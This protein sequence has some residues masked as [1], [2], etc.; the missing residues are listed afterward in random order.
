[1]A[2][3]QRPKTSEIVYTTWNGMLQ[4][5]KSKSFVSH[6]KCVWNCI[7]FWIFHCVFDPYQKFSKHIRNSGKRYTYYTKHCGRNQNKLIY[8]NCEKRWL[9]LD[10]VNFEMHI[11]FI[12]FHQLKLLWSC[13]FYNNIPIGHDSTEDKPVFIIVS[14]PHTH[15]TSR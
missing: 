11:R 7:V 12:M 8:S 5:Y 4:S 1:M 3:T 2:G 15:E 14:V 10:I 6:R 13:K 9:K